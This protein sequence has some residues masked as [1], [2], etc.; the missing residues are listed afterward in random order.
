MNTKCLDIIYK[1]IIVFSF[2]K[3]KLKITIRCQ[4]VT[5]EH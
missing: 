3:K 2:Q 4:L 1:E 5:L